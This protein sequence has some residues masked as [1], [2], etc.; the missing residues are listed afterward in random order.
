MS[1]Q[2]YCESQYESIF[3]KEYAPLQK[4]YK[5]SV[6]KRK[7]KPSASLLELKDEKFKVEARKIA[8]QQTVYDALKKFPKPG[9]II[10]SACIISR[11]LSALP[12]H[13]KQ[14]F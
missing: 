5:L 14:S 13:Y 2:E 10:I 3:T 8:I 4:K 11:S 12:T 1:V 7:T 6:E 9:Y